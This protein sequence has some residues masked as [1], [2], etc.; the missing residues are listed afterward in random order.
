MYLGISFLFGLA[1]IALEYQLHWWSCQGTPT[2]Q[3]QPRTARVEFLLE[4]K[5]LLFNVALATIVFTY[6][7]ANLFAQS[8][9][10]CQRDLD[11]STGIYNGEVDLSDADDSFDDDDNA[12]DPGNHYVATKLWWFVS[13][14][15]ILSQV[16]E[17]VFSLLFWLRVVQVDKAQTELENRMDHHELTEEQWANRCHWMCQ[18]LSIS[19]CFLFGGQDL[20][21]S[22]NQGGTY[23]YDHL[24]KV[25]AD[26]LETKGTLDIVPTDLMTG[27]LILQ[28]LQ[29]QRILEARL[30][31]VRTSQ[32][33]T[34]QRSI[35]VVRAMGDS[36]FMSM[37]QEVQ[38]IP[39]QS[40][41]DKPP[42]NLRAR[43]AS[44]CDLR[45]SG[46]NRTLSMVET[47]TPSPPVTG[48]EQPETTRLVGNSPLVG[49]T[50]A[51][52]PIYRLLQHPT[53]E[54]P[55][56]FSRHYQTHSRAV[57]NPSN[58]IDCMRLNEGAHMAKFALSI[59]TWML[60]VFVHPVTGFP[61]LCY[62]SCCAC[63][64]QPP[65]Q[66]RLHSTL[67]DRSST[68]ARDGGVRRRRTRP[69]TYTGDNMCGWHKQSLMLV[70][71]LDECDIVYAQFVNRF[72][73]VPYCILLDHST[74]SV[75]ISVRGSL[76]LDDL[77]TDVHLDP[78]PV[79]HLGEEF[80]FDGAG[81]FCHAGVVA[82][83]RNVYDDLQAHGHLERLLSGQEY[84]EYKLR[85][86]GHSLG[87]AVCTLLGYMLRTKYPNLKVTNF[88]PPGTTMTWGLATGCESWATT[89]VLDSDIVPRL[90]V[91]AM[92]RLRN[93]TLELIG[94]LKVPKYQVVESFWNARSRRSC[95]WGTTPTGDTAREDLS[96]LTEQ[97]DGWLTDRHSDQIPPTSYHRQLKEFHQVQEDRKQTR[98][99]T[100]NLML[101]PPGRMI[102]LLKTGEEGGM[103]HLAKKV[104]TCCTSNSGF[105]YTPIYIANDDLDEIVVSPTMA[106]DHFVD[107]MCDELESL[108]QSYDDLAM[109]LTRSGAE[110]V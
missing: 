16:M 26:Y 82:C 70:A 75:V 8:F 37:N 63:S 35:D 32:M 76:S 11:Y 43:G 87:A 107:R 50:S 94:R 93:E 23:Y 54:H 110:I 39:I 104:A 91:A 31:V 97:I 27:L 84:P 62:R 89:F 20:V 73:M 42:Q 29:R 2:T 79:D 66:S 18:C 81:Q 68:T 22:N 33:Q 64:C 108:A 109:G 15:F 14:V 56:S 88:G 17:I 10:Q 48:I 30:Q 80:G 100:R 46:T 38:E 95:F 65:S 71:G 98:G 101:Y 105:Q 49:P 40:P 34:M 69:A 77:V 59:Y 74:A 7:C 103:G 47:P 12:L 5:L 86:T 44:S 83:A 57:L 25:L 58:P 67:L 96:D 106:T 102:H 90:S 99:N 6:L 45:T 60:Y 21:Q 13:A 28:R 55:E 61:R 52:R 36:D 92:E 1:S 78:E 19:T 72:S 3:R 85:L 4:T 24:S 41:K 51:T 9:M 53:P